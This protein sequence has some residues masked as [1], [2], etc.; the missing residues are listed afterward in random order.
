[1]TRLPTLTPKQFSK[2]LKNA[3]FLM[4]HWEGSHETLI[5][6]VKG[7]RVVVPHHSRDLKRGLMKKLIKDATLSESK[8]RELI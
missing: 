8:F 5:H 6:P 2:A 3:G 4:D 7:L 1:M